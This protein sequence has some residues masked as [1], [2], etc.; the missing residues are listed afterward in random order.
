MYFKAE[1]CNPCKVTLPVVEKVSS[2]M[3]DVDLE[4]INVD[5]NPELVQEYK[6][7]SI[8][9]MFFLDDSGEII[10]KHVGGLTETVL[11]DKVN[12]LLKS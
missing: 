6:V 5:E 2:D 12:L 9:A 8:P 3:S 7:R 1:W 10:D 11:I 4:I